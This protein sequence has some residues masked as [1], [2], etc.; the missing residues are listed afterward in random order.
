MND[1]PAMSGAILQILGDPTAAASMAAAGRQRVGDHFTIQRTA[2]QVQDIFDA[3]VPI[4]HFTDAAI[5]IQPLL[6]TGP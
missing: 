5:P 4:T 2:R 6:R 1:A 3:V